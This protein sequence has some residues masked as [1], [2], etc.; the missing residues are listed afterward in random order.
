MG[1]VLSEVVYFFDYIQYDPF[2]QI[3][4]LKKNTSWYASDNHEVRTDCKIHVFANYKYLQESGISCLGFYYATLVR[5]NLLNKEDALKKEQLVKR[6]IMEECAKIADE[7]GV[8]M[9][10]RL[11]GLSEKQETSLL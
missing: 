8:K 3:A 6:Y 5:K 1:I 4:V 7:L 9:D 10:F 2:K 11:S